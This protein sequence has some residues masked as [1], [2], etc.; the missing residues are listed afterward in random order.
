MALSPWS[1]FDPSS[2]YGGTYQPGSFETAPAGVQYF[3]KNADAWWTRQTSPFSSGL[4]PFDRFVQSRKQNWMQGY[5]AALGTNPEL[6]VPQYG[7]QSPLSAKYF[8]GLF[9]DLAPSQRGE[10]SS[11]GGGGRLRWLGG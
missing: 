8:Q 1:S 2:W 5:D 6:T 10:S 4:Q 3:N 7:A 9:S 11:A